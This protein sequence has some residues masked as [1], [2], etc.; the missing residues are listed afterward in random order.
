MS[1][2]NESFSVGNERGA[3]SWPWTALKNYVESPHFFH[4]YFDSQ[5]FFLVPKSGFASSDEV[6]EMRQL[7][8]AKVAS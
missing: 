3:R 4:L 7:L 1:F 5:S 8:K 2:G 6:Y